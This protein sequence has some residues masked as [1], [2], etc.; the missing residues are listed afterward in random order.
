MRYSIQAAGEVDD[1]SRP[2]APAA[3][4]VSATTPAQGQLL[5]SHQRELQ[6][7][8]AE[9]RRA[10]EARN[11]SQQ[12][13][14]ERLRLGQDQLRAL[15][16]GDTRRLP[17][18]VF[19]I[20]QLRRVAGALELDLD[21]KLAELRGRPTAAPPPTAPA[22]TPSSAPAALRTSRPLPLPAT[23]LTPAS[24]ASRE[25]GQATRPPS[26]R[27]PLW[28]VGALLALPALALALTL[29]LGRRGPQ[30]Q[31]T[32]S[33]A[34]SPTA[35]AAGP[36][37]TNKPVMPWQGN[38]TDTALPSS[39]ASTV[40]VPSAKAS[41][42]SLQLQANEASWL[43]VRNGRGEVL[44]QGSFQGERRFPLQG[45]LRLL[46]GRPDLIAVA[47]EGQPAR[48]LGPI[49]AVV[50]YSFPA[51]ASASQSP[52]GSDGQPAAATT[53]ELATP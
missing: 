15:E 7:L 1:A 23:S 40:G 9:L 41:P 11:L 51:T 53:P 44:F 20:A 43:E 31:P 38:P 35:N 39:R 16:E 13:L 52:A 22:P 8:G 10:R 2:K 29:G 48:K 14:A 34:P 33:S 25:G 47:S 30:P 3:G 50:W 6:A 19:V 12:A 24:P 37:P 46:P 4:G 18:L 45:G 26:A 32:T 28:R 5:E 42:A 21:D 27:P 17:E 49:Y 36:S